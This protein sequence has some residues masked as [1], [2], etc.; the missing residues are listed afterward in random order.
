MILSRFPFFLFAA[1]LADYLFKA[2]VNYRLTEE[3][4]AEWSD[5]EASYAGMLGDDDG[6]EAERA[7]AAQERQ[8]ARNRQT[9]RNVSRSQ[10]VSSDI[11]RP[12]SEE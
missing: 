8:T 11:R 9:M 1:A 6:A 5:V 3:G 7:Q 12:L 2:A 4:A 10:S